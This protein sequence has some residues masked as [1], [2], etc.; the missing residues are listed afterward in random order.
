MR[1][2]E[3]WSQV[4]NSMVARDIQGRPIPTGDAATYRI[5][6]TAR[7]PPRYSNAGTTRGASPSSIAST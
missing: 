7:S 2:A 6:L 1:G 5:R 3:A 4:Q